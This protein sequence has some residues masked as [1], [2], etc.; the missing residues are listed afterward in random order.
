MLLR[1]LAAIALIL[2]L[3]ANP[4]M[5]GA[6]P[7]ALVSGRDYWM[8]PT[9]ARSRRPIFAAY[10]STDLRTWKREGTI[11][12]LDK[13][14]W[15]KADGAPWHG[16]WA[17]GMTEKGG[18]FYFYYSV[19]PQDPTPSRIGVAVG[20]SPTGPFTDSGKPLLTGGNGFEA[21]DPMVFV[22]PADDRAWFYAGGSAGATLRVFEM[23]PDMVS[24]KREVTVKQPEKFTEGAFMHRRGKIYYLS[25][26]HGKW[27]DSS[28][29]VH[30]A[31]ASSPEGPWHYRGCVLESDAK[32]Q[33]PGHHS[34]VE[35]PSTK[36]WF[37]VYHRWETAKKEGPFRGGRKIAVEKVDYDDK[38]LIKTIRMT[39]GKSPVSPVRR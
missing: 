1:L 4:V 23:N 28:Y 37:I 29:S 38:G 32:H 15:V 6:D 9:E 18:K 3:P 14:P 7:H 33:G 10:R 5:D 16:A 34:F 11:L 26:S 13:V 36:E 20:D 2:P 27:N 17:P 31:T 25:Y 12:D 19:G 21:I 35:N 24:F 39:D 22:D 30:Y 8:Y